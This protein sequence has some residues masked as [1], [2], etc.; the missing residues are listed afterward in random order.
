MFSGGIKAPPE[1]PVGAGLLHEGSGAVREAVQREA[2][3]VA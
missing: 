3:D 1:L 2:V